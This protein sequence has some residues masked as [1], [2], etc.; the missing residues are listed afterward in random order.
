MATVNLRSF[1]QVVRHNR[2]R[3]RGFLT[4]LRNNPPRG[5]DELKMEADKQAWSRTDCL[6]CANCCKTMSPTY[7]QKD[8]KRIAAHLGMTENAFREKWLYKDRTGDW[9][10]VKQPCQFLD[11][12]TNMCNIYAV[13][14][15]DCAGFPHH[16]KRKMV[17]YMHMYQQNIEY[18]PA[19]Y[20]VVEYIQEKLKGDVLK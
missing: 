15:A 1:R 4:R 7:T 12:K 14:P 2:R 19:T 11:L 5:L 9:M 10:N 20:R 8:V 17:E 18:C 16:N 3:L 6:D 13:R